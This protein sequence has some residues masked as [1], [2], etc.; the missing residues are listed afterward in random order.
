MYSE[1]LIPGD[2]E[3]FDTI[4]EWPEIQENGARVLTWHSDDG[5]LVLSY[6]AV[7]RSVRVLWSNN[8]GD[9]LMD[10]Y[11]EGATRLAFTS[12]SSTVGAQIDFSV[13]ECAG[14]MEIDISPRV[15]VRDRLLF[16]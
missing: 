3:I 13:G 14:V 1:F 15:S 9:S 6:E 10:V 2:D 11:R 8:D 4:G 12:T 5:V 7:T 16:Q